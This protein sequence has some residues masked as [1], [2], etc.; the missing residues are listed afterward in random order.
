MPARTP[1]GLVLKAVRKL[2]RDQFG[3]T[4]RHAL[5][6]HTDE[7]HPHVHVVVKAVGEQGERLNIRKATLRDWRRDFAANLRELGVAAN[8]T[9]RAVRGNTKSPIPDGIY[10]A[11]LRGD[12]FIRDRARMPPSPDLMEVSAAEELRRTRA[13]VVNGWQAVSKRFSEIG[14]HSLARRVERFTSEMPSL[15]TEA[16]R[17]EERSRP[18]QSASFLHTFEKTR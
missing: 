1:P 15:S 10:R 13:D 7:S 9:E 16:D 14:Y 8:A 6:L 12:P 5:V 4:Y 11:N 2:A 18:G 3:S 17:K